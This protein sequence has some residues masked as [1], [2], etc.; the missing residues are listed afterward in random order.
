MKHSVIKALPRAIFFENIFLIIGET[1][2]NKQHIR[3]NRG[4]MMKKKYRRTLRTNLFVIL[5]GVFAGLTGLNPT[6]AFALVFSDFAV[7]GDEQ[8]DI[9][10]N[11]FIRGPLGSNADVNLGSAVTTDELY[12]GGDLKIGQD[13]IVDGKIVSN[14]NVT[15]GSGVIIQGSVDS[16][17]ETTLGQHNIAAGNVTAGGRAELKDGAV[18]KGRVL[19]GS[20]FQGG[21]NSRIS[22]DLGADGSVDLKT[23]SEVEGAVTHAGTLTLHGT[24]SV[25]SDAVGIPVVVPELFAPVSLPAAASFT[26]GS[27]HVNQGDDEITVLF[28]GT[29]GNLIL[30]SD[31]VLKLASGVYYFNKITAGDGLKLKIDLTS[32]DISIFVAGDVML[33]DDLRVSLTNGTAADIYSEAHGRWLM[34]SNSVWYGTIF[35]PFARLEI[36][37]NSFITGALYGEDQIKIGPDSRIDFQLADNLNPPPPN[38]PKP[39]APEPGTLFLFSAGVSLFLFGQIRSCQK[40]E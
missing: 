34:N 11:S 24:A 19:S 35:A 40:S 33:G 7:F 1:V 13:S 28:P 23:G 26:A 12:A 30:G 20:N 10:E 6:D 18:V 37:S 5:F 36:G 16:G 3:S 39:V 14:K 32:G 17:N 31:N 4:D 9:G 15:A 2:L 8:V 25:G 21:Q 29:Y 22:G 27:N 38:P